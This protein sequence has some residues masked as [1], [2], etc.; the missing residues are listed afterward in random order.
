MTGIVETAVETVAK[1]ALPFPLNLLVSAWSW[2]KGAASDAL[3]WVTKSVTHLLLAA[4]AVAI[5]LDLW[6]WHENAAL[7]ARDGKAI[8]AWQRLFTAEQ[9]AFRGEKA[10]AATL[11]GQIAN[12]NAGIEAL[13]QA[14]DARAKAAHATLAGAVARG[15]ALQATAT[16]LR[17]SAASGPAAADCKTPPAILIA[18]EKQ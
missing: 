16:Q 6:Q 1:A 8:A 5:A 4:L 12:Q 9:A 14:S 13:H 7:A 15:D 11:T 17:A 10:F 3:A 2:I 18:L